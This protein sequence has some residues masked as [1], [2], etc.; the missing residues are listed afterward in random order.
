MHG[1]TKEAG[2]R[3]PAGTPYDARDP[4]LLMWVHAT[5][6]HTAMDVYARYVGSLSD[7]ER[8]AYYEE[9]KL[10][11]EKFGVPRE[12]QPDTLADFEAYWDD[13]LRSDRLAVTGALR[14]VVDATLRPDLP[15]FMR[16]VVEGL[17]LAT[18]GLLPERMRAELG[19]PWGRN[20][21]RLFGAGRAVLSAALPVLP[22][23]MREFP[24][25]RSADKRVRRLAAAA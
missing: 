8:N 16:P 12:R 7:S 15:F 4:E 24:P 13:M 17:N 2:G 19:V 20:R 14:D 18:V 23:V 3:Y 10:L 5:L 25:A 6:V 1:V 22:R 21:Q 9:Q 11:G